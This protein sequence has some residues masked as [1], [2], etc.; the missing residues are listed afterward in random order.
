MLD[1]YGLNL[2]RRTLLQ[3]GLSL[4]SVGLLV[5]AGVMPFTAAASD[6]MRSA[7]SVAILMFGVAVPT[8]IGVGLLMLGPVEGS[9]VNAPQI[10]W[11][12]SLG[13]LLAGVRALGAAN[14][15]LQITDYGE[16]ERA[17][18]VALPI[19]AAMSVGTQVGWAMFGVLSG[20][21]LGATGA[22][23]LA[24][25]IAIAAPL[26]IVSLQRAKGKTDSP[27]SKIGLL[28][29]AASLIGLP[30]FGGFVGTLMVAQAAANISGIWLGVL[31]LGTLLLGA[32]WA[33]VGAGAW[34]SRG[35]SGEANG[36]EKGIWG[37]TPL[38]VAVLIAVQLGLFL[39]SGQLA[40]TLGNWAGTPWMFA[41]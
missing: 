28:V 18:S 11:V 7:P 5:R 34:V 40:D 37:I 15:K 13:V 29:G 32:G 31:L 17:V 26:L 10:A 38:L 6:T 1:R 9:L 21:R 20:S 30:P 27:S 41:P 12:A 14:Y 22:V 2:E 36:L 39:M 33:W 24:V 16:R 19:L 23:L 4:L 25:N 3:L 8:T 35:G